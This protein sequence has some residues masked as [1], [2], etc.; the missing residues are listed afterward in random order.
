MLKIIVT[1]NVG[2]TPL[3]KATKNNDLIATFSVAVKLNKDTTEW[4]DVVCGGKL[5]DVVKNYVVAGSKILIEGR[6]SA[7]YWLEKETKNAAG[8]LSV[9]AN[10]IELLSNKSESKNENYDLPDA[11]SVN[12]QSLESDEIPF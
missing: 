11:P 7:K 12:L 2:S 3:I 1:G 5:V 8:K 4:V 6:P 9:F 10:N